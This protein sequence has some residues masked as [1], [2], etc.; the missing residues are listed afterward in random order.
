MLSTLRIYKGELNVNPVLQL[1]ILNEKR[2]DT[3]LDNERVR[4]A[5]QSQRQRFGGDFRRGADVFF[6]WVAPRMHK[7]GHFY[8]APR[9]IKRTWT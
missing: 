6:I 8:A 9:R 2:L 5:S 3:Y 7:R 1:I 4:S